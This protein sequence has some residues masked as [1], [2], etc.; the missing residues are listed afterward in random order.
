MAE[1]KR[2][3]VI[4]LVAEAQ[5]AKV[6]Q[7]EENVK[8]KRRDD[9]GGGDAG[10]HQGHPPVPLPLLGLSFGVQSKSRIVLKKL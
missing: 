8:R 3:E 2:E 9:E 10:Q 5:E 6:S 4:L 1:A 7:G